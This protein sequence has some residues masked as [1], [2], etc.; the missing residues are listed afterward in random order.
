MEA[1][2]PVRRHRKIFWCREAQRSV[3][4]EFLQEGHWPFR[5]ETAIVACSAF[6]H[7]GLM[8]CRRGCLDP[9]YGPERCPP[10][11]SAMSWDPFEDVTSRRR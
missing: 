8:N 5:R 2:K 9:S 10:S 11:L 3:A 1:S 6:E 4:V 7:P